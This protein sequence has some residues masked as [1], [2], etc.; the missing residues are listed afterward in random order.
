MRG[1][2]QA[3]QNNE[4]SSTHNPWWMFLLIPFTGQNAV[5]SRIQSR[6]QFWQLEVDQSDGE[7]IVFV[8]RDRFYKLQIVPFG[9]SNTRATFEVMVDNLV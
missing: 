2:F 6:K 5:Q 3:K 4:T 7:I 9:P 8:A 1:L